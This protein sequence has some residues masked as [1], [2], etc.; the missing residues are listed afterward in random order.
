MHPMDSQISTSEHERV[1]ALQSYVIFGSTDPGYFAEIVC[2]VQQYF[3]MPMVAITLLN[4]DTRWVKACAEGVPV[5]LPRDRS[6][7][8]YV[9]MSDD[10][11][12]VEDARLD[13]ILKDNPCVTGGTQVRSYIGAP[14]IDRAGHRLGALC[15]ADPRPRTFAPPE[16]AWL[17]EMAAKTMRHIELHKIRQEG[18][19]AL[20]EHLLSMANA[21]QS[22]KDA[23]NAA[24]D[25]DVVRAYFDELG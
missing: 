19:R 5:M 18:H 16:N 3:S 20:R 15:A 10:V 4:S 1:A 8:H 6:F 12:T 13:G 23:D 22:R 11:M 9:I 24:R 7:S 17:K 25:I 14:L 21:A 2:A